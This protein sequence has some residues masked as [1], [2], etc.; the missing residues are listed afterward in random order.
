MITQLLGLAAL[1]SLTLTAEQDLRPNLPAFY[2]HIDTVKEV[3][4]DRCETIE[5]RDLPLLLDAARTSQR[6]IDCSGFIYRGRPAFLELMFS[7][8]QL[9]LIIVMFE[10]GEYAAIETEYREKFGPISHES[11]IGLYSYENAVALRTQPHEIV[12]VSKRVR[13]Q[14]QLYME[15]MAVKAAQ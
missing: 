11:G 15:D 9:D 3:V 6:Q 7:D 2:T 14:Y 4:S 10:P 8:D 1:A 5:I 12:F 13:A